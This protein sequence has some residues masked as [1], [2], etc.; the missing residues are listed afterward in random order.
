MQ[1]LIEF[2]GNE[3]EVETLFERVSRHTAE[4]FCEKLRIAE[5]AARA[6]LRAAPHWVPSRIRPLNRRAVAHRGLVY[7]LQ[8]TSKV[9]LLE[10]TISQDGLSCRDDSTTEVLMTS[11]DLH[12]GQ[13]LDDVRPSVL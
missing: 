8:M 13:E 7:V 2:F 6:H 9:T 4:T 12:W 5:F 1:R 11:S 10:N 3:P